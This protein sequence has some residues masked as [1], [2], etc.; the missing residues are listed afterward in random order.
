LRQGVGLDETRVLAQVLNTTDPWQAAGRVRLVFPRFLRAAGRLE[1]KGLVRTGPGKIE[2]TAEGRRSARR[3]GLRSDRQIAAAVSGARKR[4]ASIV[5]RRPSSVTAYDQGFMTI[6]SVFRRAE[7][8]MRLGDVELKRIAI[9]GDD[10]LLSL[11]ICLCSNPEAVT[12]FEIDARVVDFIRD[13]A[14]VRDFP[15]TTECID[16]RE[17]LPARLRGRFHTFVSDPS[18]TTDGLKM[19]LGR[20]L[21][22]LRSGEGRSGY[23]GLT[24]IEASI[25]KW[26]RIQRWLLNRYPLAITHILPGNAVYHNWPDILDQTSCFSSDFIT[27]RPGKEWFNSALVRLETARGFKPR[28]MGAVRGPLFNDDEACGVIGDRK[29]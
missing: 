17:P 7:L 24:T 21:F 8:M 3:L 27:H 26:N 22:L 18:E 2:L 28:D 20:G 6:D 19:F 9:L 23:F 11:A 15:I 29:E 5:R 10:D 25:A 14:R 16:L 13:A 12:V 4:F 1:R